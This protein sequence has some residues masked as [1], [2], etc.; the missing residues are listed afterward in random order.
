MNLW[1]C[2]TC[3]T[4]VPVVLVLPVVVVVLVV[5]CSEWDSTCWLRYL[6]HLKLFI[7][8]VIN[9]EKDALRWCVLHC[10]PCSVLQCFPL[11]M[12]SHHQRATIGHNMPKYAK[13]GHKGLNKQKTKKTKKK[14]S[15]DCR[16]WGHVFGFFCF[17]CCFF[18][19]FFVFQAP[20][21]GCRELSLL[22]CFSSCQ[23]MHMSKQNREC[24]KRSAKSALSQSPF[25]ESGGLWECVF[26]TDVASKYHIYA[27][28]VAARSH[29]YDIY[30][31]IYAYLK[32][33]IQLCDKK[34]NILHMHS[35]K[36]NNAI[37]GSMSFSQWISER[38]LQ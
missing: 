37:N 38:K 16:H 4:W 35:E 25:L 17:F 12:F 32:N 33:F 26:F 8:S 34:Q 27:S 31:Y 5:P 18:L 10:F 28:D 22:I 21:E 20:R 30:I 9:T 6:F 36:L 13:I 15:R 23:S 1:C 7:Q 2:S 29:L 24:V 14:K 19:F 11:A 3:S